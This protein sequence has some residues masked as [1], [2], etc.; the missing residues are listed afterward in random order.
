MTYTFGPTKFRLPDV[1][2]SQ[3]ELQDSSLFQLFP[4][5]K[6]THHHIVQGQALTFVFPSILI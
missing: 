1:E 2:R 6:P 5:L 3:K 4:L